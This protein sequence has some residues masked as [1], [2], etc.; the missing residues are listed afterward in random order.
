[1]GRKPRG[2]RLFAVPGTGDSDWQA[3]GERV[4]ARR[5]LVAEK[6]R[7]ADPLEILVFEVIDRAQGDMGLSEFRVSY[8]ARCVIAELR[9][10]GSLR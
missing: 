8:L 7:L 4:T 5:E 1:M 9:E 2:P 6:Y 3:R 10:V